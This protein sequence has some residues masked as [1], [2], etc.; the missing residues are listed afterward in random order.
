MRTEGNPKISIIQGDSYTREISF[1]GIDIELI[2]KIYFSSCGL[3]ICKGL[4]KDIDNKLFVLHLT[5]NETSNFNV[6]VFDFD[7]T[8]KF[9]NKDI[10]TIQY[11]SIISILEKCNMVMCDE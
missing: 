11:K 5:S 1:K 9:T 4:N 3:N 8:V 2:D 6:G 10:K 7:L